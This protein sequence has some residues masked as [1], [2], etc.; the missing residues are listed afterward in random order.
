MTRMDRPVHLMDPFPAPE[1]EPVA[2]CDVCAAL[3]RQRAAARAIRDKSAMV[4][5]NVEI[6]RHPHSKREGR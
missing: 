2:G 3:A 6:R 1:P 4:D 5:C